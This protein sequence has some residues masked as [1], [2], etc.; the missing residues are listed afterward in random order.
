MDNEA[1]MYH[2]EVTPANEIK[3]FTKSFQKRTKD[4]KVEDK[5]IVELLSFQRENKVVF[6]RKISEKS[7][8]NGTAQKIYAASNCD[9]FNLR[10]IKHYCK[11][12]NVEIVELELD[13]E[14]LAQKLN[15]PFLMSMV[16]VR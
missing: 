5:E 16:C 7:L 15:K 11:V 6:G 10:K 2:E 12:A 8:K 13:N 1:Q 4:K 3:G 9:D 14:E